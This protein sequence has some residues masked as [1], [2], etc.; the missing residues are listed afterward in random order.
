VLEAYVK[1][2]LKKV[3]FDKPLC[4]RAWIFPG[5][6]CNESCRF[7]YYKNDLTQV[8]SFEEVKFQIDKAKE[9]GM[10]SIDL[11][12]GEPSIHPDI[13]KI[14]EYGTKI[15]GSVSTLTNG[16]RFSDKQ[17]LKHCVDLGLNE[18]LFSVH[19]IEEVHDLVVNKKGAF[20]K[21]IQAIYNAKEL[22]LKVRMNHTLTNESVSSLDEYI[23]LVNTIK[24][25][26]INFIPENN[27]HDHRGRVSRNRNIEI[28]DQK[29]SNIDPNIEINIRYIPFCLVTNK[30]LVRSKYYHLFDLGDWNI[31][32]THCRDNNFANCQKLDDQNMY[33]KSID[34]LTDIQKSIYI[35]KLECFHC[36]YFLFCD[37]FHKDSDMPKEFKIEKD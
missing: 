22:G 30:H 6:L 29:I 10:T 14:I 23:E 11:S 18:I 1:K 12:G 33:E 5:T 36:K 26:Q 3:P 16:L 34:I 8:K 4:K 7:C 28:L 35:K 19:G 27:W 32:Y 21:I 2:E 25:E 9:L 24:P 37:G 31:Y 13:L 15:F 20:Q 17:F